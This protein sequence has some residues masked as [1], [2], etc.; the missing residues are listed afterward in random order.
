MPSET[1]I[2][3]WCL[4]YLTRTVDDPSIPIG[5]DIP[6]PQM[7]LDSATSAYFIVELEEWV[8]VELEPELVFDYPTVD[9]LARHIVARGSAEW[10]QP[11]MT[12]VSARAMAPASFATLADLLRHRAAATPDDPA[13]I[14]LSDR[15]QELAR[16]T[17]AELARRS[18][19]LARRIADRAEPGDRALLVC[20]NGIGFMVGF[21]ACVLARVAAVPI[22]V[23]RR[24]SARDASAGI[25][26]D[27]T[28]RS[29]AR[30]AR[31][32][33]R[34][35][36]RSGGALRECRPQRDRSRISGGGRCR[37]RARSSRADADR[38]PA[39]SRTTSRFCNTPPAR[40][41]RRRA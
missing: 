19:D 40:P 18:A 15:G 8:G 1:E 9:E 11:G 3:D 22:M 27:C 34:R 21:F 14:E 26:A 32:D 5:P 12:A 25:V 37:N 6:F 10:R 24:N 17:F 2:R 16:L 28:P 20:P 41:R 31:A 4:A 39:R 13:Y 29:R 30:P 23:P 7:G 33:R 38:P 36:R 35:A